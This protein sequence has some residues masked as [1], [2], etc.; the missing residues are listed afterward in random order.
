MRASLFLLLLSFYSFLPA[1][2]AQAQTANEPNEG[3]RLTRDEMT[4]DYTLKWWGQS[5]QTYFVQC[6]DDL[7]HW[8]YVP[9]IE[10]GAA[11]VI[12]YG[13]TCSND[14]FFLRLR[15]TNAATGG[16]P[17]TADFDGDKIGNMA[18][19]QAGTDPLL[20]IDADGDGMHDEWELAHGLDP[21]SSA[22]NNGANGDPDGDGLINGAEYSYGSSPTSRD[23]DQDGALDDFE[24]A[25]GT[26]LTNPLSLPVQTTTGISTLGWAF[27]NVLFD[28]KW[29]PAPV[30]QG[31]TWTK[32][33]TSSATGTTSV[34][35]PTSFA[36]VGNMLTG[37][38]SRPP[39]SSSLP[40]PSAKY[41]WST[42]VVRGGPSGNDP[43]YYAEGYSGMMRYY[44]TNPAPGA[45]ALKLLKETRLTKKLL[46][47]SFQVLTEN[48]RTVLV[49]ATGYSDVVAAIPDLNI[50][51][52]TSQEAYQTVSF[53]T[54]TVSLSWIGKYSGTTSS[55]VDPFNGKTVGTRIFPD[56]TS[57]TGADSNWKQDLYIDISVTNYANKTVFLKVFDVDDPSDVTDSQHVLDTTDSSTRKAG[58][59]NATNP[60]SAQGGFFVSNSSTLINVTLDG[61]G[62][63]SAEFRVAPQPG[64][65]YRVALGFNS[66][67]FNS[68]QVTDATLPNYVQPNDE[69]VVG[70][71]G[72]IS[73]LL[74]VWRKLH[75]EVDSMQQWTSLKPSPDRT[76]AVGDFWQ[77]NSPNPTITSTLTLGSALPQGNNF[78]SGGYISSGAVNLEIA[79][80]TDS[81]ITVLNPNGSTPLTVQEKEEFLN[82]E[83][84]VFDDDGAGLTMA[85]LPKAS[86]INDEVK[87]RFRRAYVEV[88]EVTPSPT[89]RSQLPFELNNSVLNPFTSLDDNQ[90]MPNSDRPEYWYHLLVGAYQ[91]DVTS[92]A[93]PESED[94]LLGATGAASLL[95]SINAHFSVVYSEPIRETKT[96]LLGAPGFETSVQKVL[97]A[98][99]A[100]ELAHCPGGLSAGSDHAEGGLMDAEGATDVQPEFSAAT[101]RRIRMTPKWNP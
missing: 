40:L 64:N 35:P 25:M 10:T 42:Q 83:F 34:S 49:P 29:P 27:G 84:D 73:P 21:A 90:D 85:E 32:I 59:D 30:A 41:K 101:L 4:G 61:S 50:P 87:K 91:G 96:V 11:A 26:S 12:E 44:L 100:H 94:I 58:N 55:N 19:L 33:T 63:G 76:T 13:F 79:T 16:N 92:D 89:T 99:I 67:D 75:V 95:Y 31:G 70:F 14:H 8:N 57:P 52:R 82:G 78:Y 72:R 98:T 15:Y 37:V 93:D 45:Y 46:D 68:L 48:W 22:G 28:S 65:N 80:N 66:G 39:T 9:I 97:E 86:L 1:N 77:A 56:A 6:S 2:P 38:A 69:Q 71:I 20:W 81:T 53:S 24:F 3:S 88:E 18:E 51:P 17:D 54:P 43:D 36:D 7:I 5:G 47:P 60:S 74:T 23:S 62:H